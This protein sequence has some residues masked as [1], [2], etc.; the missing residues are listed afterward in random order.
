M[1]R[2]KAVLQVT[3]CEPTTRSRGTTTLPSGM[4][5]QSRMTL[6]SRKLVHAQMTVSFATIPSDRET[7]ASFRDEAG[8]LH[9]PVL[10]E[11]I[12]AY[13]EQELPRTTEPIPLDQIAQ[14]VGL[15]LEAVESAVRTLYRAGRVSG[16]SVEERDYP[17][18]ITELGR[19]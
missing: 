4:T 12:T 16:P 5:P 11:M 15:D 8:V 18:A 1:R 2:F 10:E 6:T 9:G 14:G 7:A 17:A 19:R 13:L 3:K